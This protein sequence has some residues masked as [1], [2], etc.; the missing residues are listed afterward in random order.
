MGA[1]GWQYKIPYQS[2]MDK[3]LAEL[4]QRVFDQGEYEYPVPDFGILDEMGFFQ[5]DDGEAKITMLREYGMACVIPIYEASGT[6]GLVSALEAI[7][8]DPIKSLEDLDLLQNFSCDGTHSILDI[9]GISPTRVFGMLSPIP[10]EQLI[11]IFGTDRPTA[12]HLA[13]GVLYD[14]HSLYSRGEGVY[15]TVYGA[16]GLPESIIIAGAS[17]D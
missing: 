15:C 1:S 3:A 2:D 5:E 13:S 17:G 10:A 11:S 12:G 7:A 8:V 9:Y 6:S 16:D 4:R 14:D